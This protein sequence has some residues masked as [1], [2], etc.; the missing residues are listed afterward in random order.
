MKR[1]VAICGSR[2][3][4]ADFVQGGGGGVILTPP[5]PPV[6][7]GLKN[8]LV[9]CS[10]EHIVENHDCDLL[11]SKCFQRVQNLCIHSKSF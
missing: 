10:K 9:H 3:A 2:G 5:P 8:N 7:I 6:K 4:V 11:V 1:R